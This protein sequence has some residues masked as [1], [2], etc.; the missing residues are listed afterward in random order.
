MTMTVFRTL[1]FFQLKGLPFSQETFTVW[2]VKFNRRWIK[3]IKSNSTLRLQ[4]AEIF[5][6][7]TKIIECREMAGVIVEC[8][9]FLRVIVDCFWGSFVLLW[10]F[11]IFVSCCGSLSIFW[12]VKRSFGSV[13]F[14]KYESMTKPFF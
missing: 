1:I 5:L 12:R 9:E 7:F 13:Y 11:F 2:K 3:S 4:F 6:S 10:T 14:S 8:F